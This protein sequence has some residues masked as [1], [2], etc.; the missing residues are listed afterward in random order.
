MKSIKASI[1]RFAMMMIDRRD[2][3]IFFFNSKMS[4]KLK[5]AK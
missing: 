3:A 4:E 2:E 1:S 5:R